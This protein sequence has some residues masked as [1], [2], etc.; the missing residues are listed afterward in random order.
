MKYLKTYEN[1]NLL[2]QFLDEIHNLIKKS[3]TRD[4]KMVILMA[5]QFRF[6][7][8]EHYPEKLNEYLYRVSDGEYPREVILDMSK[9]M[10]RDDTLFEIIHAIFPK[11]E[12][13]CLKDTRDN[14]RY[15]ITVGNIYTITDEFIEN[16]IEYVE[17]ELNDSSEPYFSFPKEWFSK[18]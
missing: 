7:L 2:D 16:G 13:E 11:Y 3:D 18:I 4:D 9:N 6:Y 17:L 8:E 1:K 5:G 12:A 14:Y 15:D 10:T